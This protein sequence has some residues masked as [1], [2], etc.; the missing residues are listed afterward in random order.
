MIRAL[1]ITRLVASTG[2]VP[3]AQTIAV[4]ALDNPMAQEN[5]LLPIVKKGDILPAQGQSKFKS[6]RALKA[7]E[8][9][10]VSFELFQV[11]YPERID[12]NLCVG[13][14]RIGGEDLPPDYIV[15]E[16]SLITFDW[17]MSDSGILEAAVRL[18]GEGGPALELKAR[19]FYAPQAGQMSFSGEQGA[20]F[21]AA[22]LK[23]GEEEWGDLA[24]A[25]GPE[26]GPP[27][28]FC[29]HG[30]KNNARR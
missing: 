15:K 28:T 1:A 17:R 8:P 22:L 3:A 14:F 13:V 10:Y 25:A 20:L 30:W 7:H 18:E 29:K 16:G 12:L 2:S 24:A 27:I 6:A 5:T 19:R 23:Q 11:E 9:G 4:K 26:G 21:A